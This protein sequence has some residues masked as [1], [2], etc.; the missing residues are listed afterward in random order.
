[1]ISDINS[2]HND[3]TYA[4]QKLN[5]SALFKQT[6]DDFIV[7][8]QLP[9]QPDGS[10]SHVFL[11]VE[12]TALNTLFVIELL[13]KFSGLAAKH[14]GY[15]GLKDKQAIS[16]Q[17]FSINLEGLTEPKWEDFSYPGV[18]I[19]EITYHKKKLKI[20]SVAANEFTILLRDLQAFEANEIEKRLK[21]I[22]QF[23]VPNYFGPQ[24]FGINNQNINKAADWFTGKIKINQRSQK[25]IILSAARSFLFNQLLSLR[26]KDYGWHQL[27]AGEV[28]MLQG[29]HSIFVVE[30]TSDPEIQSRF[31]KKDIHPTLALW[32][33][34]E[35]MSQLELKKLENTMLEQFPDWCQ[36][37][38]NKGLKQQRR[39]M[40]VIP[41]NL[42]YQ[43]LKKDQLQIKFSLPKGCYATSILR[44]LAVI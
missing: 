23:G 31:E 38:G 14:I 42:K 16:T 5:C 4:Y 44:E 10:G 21:K 19:K 24:R 33:Q 26:I 18:K 6:C 22:S 1:M 32:G 8:E 30:E 28:M 15:A 34:G 13:A 40:R 29:S 9:F 11:R 7:K 36:N 2:L 20:G 17:W 39:L 35:L 25:S 37:L 12:K 41:E 43:W 27:I 3:L